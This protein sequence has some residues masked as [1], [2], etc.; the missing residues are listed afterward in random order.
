MSKRNFE[1]FM[2]CLGNGITVCNKAVM[3]HND[4][5]QIAHIS[6]N[7]IIKLYVSTDYIPCEDM[8][9][10]EQ[11]AKQQREEFLIFWNKYTV[12]EKYYKLLDMCNTADFID[13]CK[14]KSSITEKVKKL[15]SKYLNEYY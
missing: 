3:E 12:E 11:A 13:I 15:E 5:K 4:Y 10:I 9:R 7:G 14:D 6:V 8:K 1:L 2:C